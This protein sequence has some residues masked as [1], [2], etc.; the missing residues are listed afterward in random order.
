MQNAK[1]VIGDLL[2]GREAGRMGFFELI[3][4]DALREWTHQGYPADEA[5]NPVEPTEYLDMDMYF[6]GDW[7]DIMPLRGVEEVVEQT[8]EWSV[9]RNG[10]GAALKFWK[11]KSGTP[12]HIDFRMTS[13]QVWES[14]YR[15]PLL[16]LDPQRIN[17]D[18][19]RKNFRKAKQLGAWGFFGHIFTFENL[20]Q[21]AGDLCLYESVLLDPGWIK[22]YNRV[23]TDFFKAHY[24]YIFEHV[25]VPDG[26]WVYED[27]GYRSAMFCS[28]KTYEE[29]FFPYYRELIE[30]FHSY[31]LP[32]VLHSCGYIEPLL[33]AFIDLGFCGLN[34][35]ENKAGCDPLRLADQYAD[36]IAFVGGLDIRILETKDKDLIRR[37]VIELTEGMKQ[38]SAR[39]IFAT[40]HSVS[41]GV[42]YADYR[43][44]LD[45]FR[46]HMYY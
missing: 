7:W 4:P 1:A 39:F 34:P 17:L 11:N 12:E 42:D 9:K 19:F 45:A 46:E 37:K 5:G 33:P 43:C 13:R 41:T 35:M 27:L 24:R 6:A 30:F 2:A 21:S 31:D 44:A 8:E 14:N 3:W 15:E 26:I 28:P 38:R 20:R 23:Y 32:V 36:R 16:E 10:A 29:L 22:D 18:V 25:G 40:D